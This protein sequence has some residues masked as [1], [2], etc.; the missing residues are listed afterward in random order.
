MEEAGSSCG[1]GS[2]APGWEQKRLPEES[3]S[4]GR[5]GGRSASNKKPFC[6][7]SHTRR[8]KTPE[9]C[10]QMCRSPPCISPSD[11]PEWLC[12]EIIIPQPFSLCESFTQLRKVF[13][14]WGKK[15]LIVPTQAFVSALAFLYASGDP[16]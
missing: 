5:A 8:C 1:W 10:A 7:L 3:S 9:K 16:A 2:P 11:T 15:I 13:I 14:C 12:F 6:K 4:A